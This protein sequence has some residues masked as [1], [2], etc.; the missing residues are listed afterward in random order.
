M[1][2]GGVPG[3]GLASSAA[4]AA[5]G[6]PATCFGSCAGTLGEALPIARLLGS[7]VVGHLL[8]Y[9]AAC[10]ALRLLGSWTRP[11]WPVLAAPALWLLRHAIWRP[12]W[13]LCL[14]LAAS[15]YGAAETAAR[16]GQKLSTELLMQSA[17]LSVAW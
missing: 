3:E 11:A 9:P 8:A 1:P 6:A 10:L 7:T 13:W 2:L 5:A 12:V 16:R 17:L 4:S 14:P 15:C